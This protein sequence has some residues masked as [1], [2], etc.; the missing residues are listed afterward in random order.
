M[1]LLP[2]IPVRTNILHIPV[3][4]LSYPGLTVVIH[5]PA[6]EVR[7]VVVLVESGQNLIMLRTSQLVNTFLV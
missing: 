3:P 1:T 6:Q 4:R 7:Q 2:S 5:K